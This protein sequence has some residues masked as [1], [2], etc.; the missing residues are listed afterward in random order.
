MI[1]RLTNGLVCCCIL[2][3]LGSCAQ[4]ASVRASDWEQEIPELM[5]TYDIPG[6]VIAVM[7]QGDISRVS[8]YGYADRENGVPMRTD[9]VCRVESIS[10]SLTAWGIMHL[11]EQGTLDVHAPALSYLN[12]WRPPQD[13]PCLDQITIGQLLSH[14][15]G[16]DLGT[17]GVIYDP[18][19]PVPSLEQQLSEDLRCISDQQNRF[20][21]SNTGYNLLEKIIED[22]T[23]TDFADYMHTEILEP[24]GM[25]TATFSWDE[26]LNIPHGHDDDGTPIPPYVYPDKAS[27]GLFA[28]VFDIAAF[29]SAGMN[30]SSSAVLS[31]HAV[32]QIYREQAVPTGYY[33]LVFDGYGYGHFIEILDNGLRAYSHGGQGTG[34][35]THFHSIPETG[36]ALIILTN[37]QRS[38]PFIS[39]LL[40]RW[41]EETGYSPI[42]M[43]LIE[44]AGHILR[45]VLIFLS[46]ILVIKTLFLIKAIKDR[47][48]IFSPLHPDHLLIRMLN[49]TAALLI[50]AG[51]IWALSQPY[52]FIT[53]VFPI[54]SPY[55][56]IIGIY[57]VV[58]LSL[59]ALFPPSYRSR[60]KF[61]STS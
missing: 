46:A 52:L 8:A 12:T 26:G 11:V 4:E 22:V 19:G 29:L 17:I 40:N 16:L 54:E 42:G 28:T 47:R 45:I 58:L 20:F 59:Q 23:R 51:I 50:A 43:G 37:S 15:A 14:Q 44:K 56:L 41:G 3:T 38:W 6:A 35:M 33:S 9:T 32:D 30:P 24:L 1:R 49:A 7:E 39:A 27:G 21:Y 36:D 2:F 13:Q 18:L 48:R 25:E 53:S 5:E 60:E 57:S 10:K 55:L 34:W 31:Q 61:D